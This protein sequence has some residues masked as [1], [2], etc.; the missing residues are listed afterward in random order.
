LAVIGGA[1]GIFVSFRTNTSYARWWEGRQLWGRMVNSSRQ[2]ALQLSAS[3]VMEDEGERRRTLTRLLYRH[4]AYVHA[5]TRGA[6]G[7]ARPGGRGASGAVWPPTELDGLKG[8]VECAVCAL[9]R[10]GGRSFAA[11]RRAGALDGLQ[12]HSLDVTLAS[13]LD[14][15]GGCERIKGTPIPRGYGYAAELLVQIYAVMLPFGLVAELGPLIVL[16]NL[17]VCM[18][19]NLI[20]EVGRVLEDPFTMFYNGL[21]L[22]DLSRK[23]EIN[24]RQ[25]L[26]E[27]ELPPLRQPA[28]NGV[29]M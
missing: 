6:A 21:P 10:P 26:G 14:I 18:A 3:L 19:F 13:L 17:I 1:L 11:L 24:L 8:R 25:T 27:T 4:G 23:I 12:H 2:L 29:L 22:S 28:P 15:Q 5:L 9:A 16:L 7:A 20:S